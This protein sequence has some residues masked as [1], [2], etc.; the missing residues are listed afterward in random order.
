MNWSDPNLFFGIVSFVIGALAGFQGIYEMYNRDSLG[1]LLTVPGVFYLASRGA[2]PAVVF[3]ALYFGARVEG[4]LLIW[5][6]V[7][8][9]GAEVLLRTKIS[10]RQTQGEDGEFRELL[11]GPLDLLRWYESLL[12]DSAAPV[13]GRKRKRL[14]ESR[15]IDELRFLDLYQALANS[16]PAWP[17]DDERAAIQNDLDRLNAEHALDIASA[18]SVEERQ[19]AERNYCLQVGYMLLNHVGPKGFKTLI[20]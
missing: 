2:V 10:L 6:M 3:I 13:I 19:T 9:T 11:K 1:V 4:N 8:G 12:L 18:S 17:N 15:I 16:L 5:S 20:P 14:V 7:C